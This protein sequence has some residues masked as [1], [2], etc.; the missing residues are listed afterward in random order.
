MRDDIRK[1]S[2]LYSVSYSI[3]YSIVPICSSHPGTRYHE[4]SFGNAWRDD[5]TSSIDRIV[6]CLLFA[7]SFLLQKLIGRLDTIVR[8]LIVI[9]WPRGSSVIAAQVVTALV[10][11]LICSNV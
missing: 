7:H 3:N 9:L 8:L 6:A 2:V 4:D 11:G 5:Y 10:G 1:D